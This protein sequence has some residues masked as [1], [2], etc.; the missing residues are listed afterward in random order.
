MAECPRLV[1]NKT[2]YAMYA[3]LIDD[4]KAKTILSV[5]VKGKNIKVAKEL[6]S[7]V[8]KKASAKKISRAVFDRRGCRYHGAIK[9]VAEAVREGGLRI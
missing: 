1:V 5:M 4:Q 9:A 7:I 8:A 3:Q 6:G 2:N